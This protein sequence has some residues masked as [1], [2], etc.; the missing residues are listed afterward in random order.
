[1][2]AEIV[3]L[4]TLLKERGK[5]QM[6][7]RNANYRLSAIGKSSTVVRQKL[8]SLEEEYEKVE[9]ERDQLYSGF[10]E[11]IQRVK[12]QSEF[13]NQALEQRLVGAETNVEKAALQVEEIIH[14]ANLDSNEV[15]R[16]MASLNQM[17]AAKD[18]ML[19]NIRFNVI[20]LQ[21][22]YN[23]SLETFTAKMKELGIPESEI[24]GNNNNTFVHEILPIGSTTAPSI[25]LIAQS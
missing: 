14:A 4:Q 13:V 1:M 5:D 16:M 22:S 12:Q 7:L 21:K 15:S 2:I 20:K 8:Q 3:E 17:L 9:K 19:K 25:I 18:E 10:E 11:S 6:A 24:R 23:D